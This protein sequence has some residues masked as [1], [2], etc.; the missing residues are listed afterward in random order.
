MPTQ[1]MKAA[2]EARARLRLALITVLENNAPPACVVD[3]DGGWTATDRLS[4]QLAALACCGCPIEL[5]CA[6]AGQYE[7]YG[8]W[9]G[10]N[11][12]RPTKAES[13]RPSGSAVIVARNPWGAE[14]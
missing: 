11:R 5:D 2:S 10:R 3:P 13:T 14:S 8:V 6:D 12:E 1:R 7:R 4:R 9:G